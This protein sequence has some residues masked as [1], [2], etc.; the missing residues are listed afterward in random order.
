[1]PRPGLVPSLL[2]LRAAQGDGSGRRGVGQGA[3]R[4]VELAGALNHDTAYS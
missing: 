4:A 2:H 3:A 1:M